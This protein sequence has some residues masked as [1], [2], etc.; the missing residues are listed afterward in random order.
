MLSLITT[1]FVGVCPLLFADEK[2]EIFVILGIQFHHGKS[3]YLSPVGRGRG[4]LFCW[5][6]TH[7]FQGQGEGSV[8]SKRA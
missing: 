5:G 1:S 8:A 6:G 7:G 2:M 3:H 4:I